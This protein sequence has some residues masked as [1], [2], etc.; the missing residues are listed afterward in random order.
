MQQEA[1]VM[2]AVPQPLYPLIQ[3]NEH[4]PVVVLQV[5]I[6][7]VWAEQSEEVQQAAAAIQVLAPQGFWPWP[8][9]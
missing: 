4:W 7:P 3:A 5:P 9:L 8:Q 2:Q 6:C 1:V